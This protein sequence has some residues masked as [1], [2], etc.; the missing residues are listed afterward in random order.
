[1]ACW[2]LVAIE[3]YANLHE[4]HLAAAACSKHQPPGGCWCPGHGAILM[5]RA[6]APREE[7]RKAMRFMLAVSLAGAGADTE[8]EDKWQQ[9][10]A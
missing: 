9:E 5:Q 2:G 1:M 8:E 7:G 10:S 6:K 4:P 3:T